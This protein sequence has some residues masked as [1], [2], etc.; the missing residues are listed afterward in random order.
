M[1]M[2]T[3]VTNI[4]FHIQIIPRPISVYGVWIKYSTQVVHDGIFCTGHFDGL[5]QDCRNSIASALE[6]LQSCT[7]PSIYFYL[8]EAFQFT[9]GS[10]N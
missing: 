5:V 7:K 4:N 9:V 2:M 8:K 10:P 1:Y 3:S 6:L